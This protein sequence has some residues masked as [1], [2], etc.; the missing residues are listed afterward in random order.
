MEFAEE[1]RALKPLP[2]H[3]GLLRWVKISV[4][5]QGDTMGQQRREPLLP[6]CFAWLAGGKEKGKATMNPK[7]MVAV[8]SKGRYLDRSMEGL[9]EPSKQ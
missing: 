8:C 9:H 6:L 4:M 5:R 7:L 2:C 1:K 3:G